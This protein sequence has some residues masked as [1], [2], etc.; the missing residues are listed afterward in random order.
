MKKEKTKD[1]VKENSVNTTQEKTDNNESNLK[2][3]FIDGNLHINNMAVQLQ[4]TA[5]LGS[6]IEV[7]KTYKNML[8]NIL[9]N[10]VDVKI[11]YN[12]TPK[13]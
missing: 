1:K 5:I 13:N 11:T 4:F 12:I 3:E 8:E 6:L 7:S 9:Q 10:Q 2:C